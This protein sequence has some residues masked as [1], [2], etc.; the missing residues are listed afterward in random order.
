M[1][2]AATGLVGYQD[3]SMPGRNQEQCA[4]VK[5]VLFERPYVVSAGTEILA[6]VGDSGYQA[7]PSGPVLGTEVPGSSMTY[8]RSMSVAGRSRRTRPSG[9]GSLVCNDESVV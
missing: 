8:C 2:M 5:E 7:N 4:V 6:A 3:G 1:G 9:D